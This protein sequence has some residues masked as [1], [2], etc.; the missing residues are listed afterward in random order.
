MME[1]V[2]PERRT[3]SYRRR[4]RKRLTRALWLFGC[5][6]A[7][8]A[9][10]GLYPLLS[11]HFPIFAPQIPSDTDVPGLVVFTVW[12]S[13]AAAGALLAVIIVLSL[14]WLLA[15]RAPPKQV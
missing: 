11:P 10:V 13:I 15:G 7:L 1:P 8:A 3:R 14:S 2:V 5:M 12:S 6:G 9:V 4:S